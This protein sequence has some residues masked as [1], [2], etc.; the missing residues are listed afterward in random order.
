MYDHAQ[1]LFLQDELHHFEH[2]LKKL[3]HLQLEHEAIDGKMK[4]KNLQLSDYP[5]KQNKISEKVAHYIHKVSSSC[6]CKTPG[7]IVLRYFLYQ[8]IYS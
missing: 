2:K 6:T 8:I 5:E 3:E 4:E 7:G 1:C